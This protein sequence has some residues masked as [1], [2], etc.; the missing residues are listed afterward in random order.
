M[1]GVRGLEGDDSVEDGF[2]AGLSIGAKADRGMSGD[3]EITGGE[4]MGK[5]H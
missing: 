1:E 4:G 5:R 3:S 2:E